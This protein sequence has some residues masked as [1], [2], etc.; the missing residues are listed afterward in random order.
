MPPTR[1]Q[2]PPNMTTLKSS[3]RLEPDVLEILDNYAAAHSVSRN[4]ALNTLI[5]ASQQPDTPSKLPPKDATYDDLSSELASIKARLTKLEAATQKTPA[6]ATPEFKLGQVITGQHSKLYPL[7]CHSQTAKDKHNKKRF[8][9]HPDL[10][11]VTE[12]T[13]SRSEK[14]KFKVVGVFDPTIKEVIVSEDNTFMDADGRWYY[15]SLEES[16]EEPLEEPV[17]EPIQES[18]EPIESLA[19]IQEVAVIAPESTLEVSGDISEIS[20]DAPQSTL[21]VTPSLP[22]VTQ[23]VTLNRDE[24]VAKFGMIRANNTA[25]SEAYHKTKD[26]GFW[27]AP[28][29]TTWARTGDNRKALWTQKPLATV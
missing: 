11:L 4:Q 22:E 25:Y 27:T 15:Q 2:V 7:L 13:A 14:K 6:D 26:G 1:I 16:V 24:F 29:G 8:S 10:G 28:D 17:E 9:L 3:F 5:R 23:A 20:P 21:K 19:P 18:V 12:V